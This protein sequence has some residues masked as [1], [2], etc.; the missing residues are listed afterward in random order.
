[1]ITVVKTNGAAKEKIMKR[2]NA[3]HRKNEGGN[4]L[5]YTVLGALFLFLAVGLGVDLSH[6]YLAKAELQNAA[7]AGALAGAKGLQHN[8]VSD[9]IAFAVD[10]A[11][12]TMNLNKYNFNNRTFAGDKT[13]AERRA[14]VTFAKTLTG[15]YQSEAAANADANKDQFKF[16]KVSTPSVPV[17][18]FFASP[19]LGS[20]Q[21]LNAKA[22]AG[23][24][25]GS[26][27]CVYALDPNPDNNTLVAS[28]GS[29][30]NAPCGVFSNSTV[31][32]GMV[33]SGGACITASS[34]SVAGPCP[35]GCI[36]PAPQCNQPPVA[37]PLAY[38]TP[39]TVGACNYTDFTATAGQV[40]NPGVYCNGIT[41][42]SKSITVNP[43]T[44]ILN[45]GGLTVSGGGSISGDGVTFFNTAQGAYASKYDKVSVNG[46]LDL[47]AP[48]TGPL[49][50]ILF[51]QDPAI[52]FSSKINAITG[53]SFLSLDGALYFR[54]TKIVFSGGS[55][56]AA[57]VSSAI[58][59]YKIEF[60]GAS[61]TVNG[62]GPG[63]VSPIGG[64]LVVL[65]K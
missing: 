21:T 17:N 22:T 44:Y 41:V 59:A 16:V 12:N 11:V 51:Y 34:V 13:T 24:S 65:Y 60:S 33:A 9:R 39:P 28:G 30:I 62:S 38:L 10:Q 8:P 56:L 7:D 45:G 52:G 57:T 36:T 23:A 25:G 1:M 14:L 5:V 49:A 15:D 3:S 64:K 31:S 50:G 40:L 43:G 6:L 63:G 2:G 26:G 55:G 53:G 42:S 54:T 37:D 27:G 18:V 48:T 47:S 46:N 58:V 35:V 19:I 61:W 4:V 20:S 32:G 29:Q